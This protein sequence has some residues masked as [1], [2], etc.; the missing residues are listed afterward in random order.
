M[1]V[2]IGYVEG[3]EV[4]LGG[5]SA[6]VAGLSLVT[7]TDSKVFKNRD[8]IFGFTSSFRMGQILRYRFEPP[9]LLDWDVEKYMCTDFIDSIRD[10]FKEYG[11]ARTEE[12]SDIGGTFMVGFRGRLFKIQCD[13]QV[14]W[15]DKGYDACGCGEDLARGAMAILKETN[16]APEEKIKKA[17]EATEQW[18]AG[19]RSPFNILKL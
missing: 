6:G 9:E 11:F 15:T 8:M 7:R 5:D 17:L 10:C 14:G 2:I 12:S 1:T 4:F 3:G 18:S 19:V 13:Y 16:L